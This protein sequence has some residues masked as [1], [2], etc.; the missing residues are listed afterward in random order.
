MAT[1][2]DAGRA[3]GAINTPA[4]LIIAKALLGS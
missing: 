4:D 1:I 3:N 2:V